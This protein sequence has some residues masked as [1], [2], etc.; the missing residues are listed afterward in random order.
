M[1]NVTEYLKDNN[2]LRPDQHIRNFMRSVRV[3]YII[4]NDKLK[5]EIK[6]GRYGGSYFDN[7]LFSLFKDWL[8]KKPIKLL[9]RKEYEVNEFLQN[10]YKVDIYYQYKHN[11]FIYDWY[12]ISK[13]LFVEFNEKTHNN[14]SIKEKDQLKK[15][16]NLFVINEDSVMSD[17][18]EL[19]SKYP[20][21]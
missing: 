5:Y 6:P 13:N 16:D 2:Y 18:S 1:I 3:K 20:N 7:K 10:Y 21:K 12:I 19:V 11:N 4:K 8:E 17:L 14:K 9:N 15:V